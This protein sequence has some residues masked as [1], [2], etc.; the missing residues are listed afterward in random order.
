[1]VENLAFAFQIF[2]IGFFETKFVL[3]H[4]PFDHM[5]AGTQMRIDADR[6]ED[7]F[8]PV[9]MRGAVFRAG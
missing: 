1:V 3:C 5:N 4:V 2:E 6:S 7:L 9:G 8:D